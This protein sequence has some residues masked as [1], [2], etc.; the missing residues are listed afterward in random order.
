MK[1]DVREL[2]DAIATS[3]RE[4]LNGNIVGVDTDPVSTLQRVE[5]AYTK[6]ATHQTAQL[7]LFRIAL[8]EQLNR[9]TPI[10]MRAFTD[11]I[12]LRCEDIFKHPDS[13]V[14][15]FCKSCTQKLIERFEE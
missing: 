7:Q 12:C 8:N 10:V 11:Y 5:S 6:Q 9:R 4:A 14:P 15:N 2:A 1:D 13:N 3:I